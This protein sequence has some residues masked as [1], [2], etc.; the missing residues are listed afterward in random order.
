MDIDTLVG[1]IVTAI[2]EGNEKAGGTAA[3]MLLGE[4]AKDIRRIADAQTLVANV[5]ASRAGLSE[6]L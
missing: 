5:E 3:L 1:D 4:V 6:R 2:N